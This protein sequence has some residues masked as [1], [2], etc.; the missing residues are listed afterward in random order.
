MTELREIQDWLVKFQLQTIPG[1][2]EILS[3][4]GFVKQYQVQIDPN[5]LQKYDITFD[6]V[7]NALK[8]NNK[9]V[10]GSFIQDGSEEYLIRGLGFVKTLSELK[11]IKIGIRNGI[12][13]YIKDVAE[14]RFGPEIRRGLISLN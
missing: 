11:V 12:P 3:Y 13:I 2:T 5:S 14:V 1:V 8:T 10:G 4:G 6:E 7:I 9:N